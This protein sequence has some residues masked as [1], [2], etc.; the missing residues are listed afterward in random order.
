M[1]TIVIML[2]LVNIINKY[3]HKLGA[4]KPMHAGRVSKNWSLRHM[5]TVI[6]YCTYYIHVVVV[7][8]HAH[9][10]Y[11][12]IIVLRYADDIEQVTGGI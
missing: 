7:Y 5:H 3:S 9:T 4:T 11:S 6:M 2:V 1:L 12:I 10:Y 8:P